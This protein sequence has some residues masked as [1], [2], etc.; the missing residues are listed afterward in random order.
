MSDTVETEQKAEDA[1]QQEADVQEAQTNEQ[2]EDTN[3]G[4]PSE[5]TLKSD[6]GSSS[7]P[8]SRLNEEIKKRNELETAVKEAMVIFTKGMPK[9]YKGLF[10]KLAIT[11]QLVWLKE[12]A[13][14][15]NKPMYTP[16]T[17]NGSGS[18]EVT[19][20]KVPPLKQSRW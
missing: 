11:D 19:L 10:D 3:D 20:D 2:V 16:K 5:Q 7:V 4:Q 14:M 12:N 8:R 6:K 17:P 13:S 1:Q 18:G 9:E 15:L